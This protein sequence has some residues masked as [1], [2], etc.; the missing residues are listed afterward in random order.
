MSYYSAINDEISFFEYDQID[1]L[2]SVH[3]CKIELRRICGKYLHDAEIHELIQMKKK[4]VE[5]NITVSVIDSPIGKN[6]KNMNSIELIKQYINIAKL[7]DCSYIRIFSDLF[8]NDINRNIAGIDSLQD[9]CEKETI[10]LLLENEVGTSFNNYSTIKKYLDMLNPNIGVLFDVCNYYMENDEYMSALEEL[11][12]YITYVHVRN[13]SKKNNEFVLI[14]EGDIDYSQIYKYFKSKDFQGG[15][16]LESHLTK[17][18]ENQMKKVIFKE[19]A[20][21]MMDIL[22]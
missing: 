11:Y 10:T 21:Q 1:A 7:F 5:N 15:F 22:D 9:M 2:N 17:D 8:G 4:L 16:S 6:K 12:E 19:A 13:Y 18:A 3:I 14:R 20:L